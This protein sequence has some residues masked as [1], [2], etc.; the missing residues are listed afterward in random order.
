MS[1]LNEALKGV[2]TNEDAR[3]LIGAAESMRTEM[4]DATEVVNH[5]IKTA[6]G[7]DGEPVKCKPYVDKLHAHVKK[8]NQFLSA[9]DKGLR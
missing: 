6:V 7:T 3:S 1:K 2:K 8:I 4:S 9:I 5:L